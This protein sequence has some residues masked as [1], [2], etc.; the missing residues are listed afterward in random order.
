MLVPI[1]FRRQKTP[2]NRKQNW[3]RKKRERERES[4]TSNHLLSWFDGSTFDVCVCVFEGGY[5]ILSRSYSNSLA[6]WYIVGISF[7][8]WLKL[9]LEFEIFTIEHYKNVKFANHNGLI[10]FLCYIQVV[11]IGLFPSYFC[12]FSYNGVFQ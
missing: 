6:N 5:S 1:K 10:V 8:I 3:L 9:W 11:S 12:S 7:E 4:E 2:N